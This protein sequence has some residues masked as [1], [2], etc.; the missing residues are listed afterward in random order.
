[1]EVW[2]DPGVTGLAG[3]GLFSTVV[4]KDLGLLASCQNVAEQLNTFS[5]NRQIL[6]IS[7]VVNAVVFFGWILGEQTVLVGMRFKDSDRG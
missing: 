4:Q 5:K 7:V 1:M 6:S 2:D 3:K